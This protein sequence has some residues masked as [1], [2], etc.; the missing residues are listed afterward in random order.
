M[1]HGRPERER[2]LVTT[3]SVHQM[4]RQGR[5]SPKPRLIRGL[6]QPWTITRHSSRVP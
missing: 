2:N 3:Y 5:E 1:L 4:P 6:E